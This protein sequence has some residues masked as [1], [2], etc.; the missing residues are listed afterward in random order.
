MSQHYSAS[1]FVETI[2]SACQL[3]GE[4]KRGGGGGYDAEVLWWNKDRPTIIL[5][6]LGLALTFLLP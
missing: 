2:W 5:V 1:S 4:R 3:T 6:R